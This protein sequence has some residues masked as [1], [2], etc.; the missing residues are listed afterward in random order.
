M[1][2]MEKLRPLN[3]ARVKH[4]LTNEQGHEKSNSETYY[5]I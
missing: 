3:L 5:G 2:E 4:Q 1:V